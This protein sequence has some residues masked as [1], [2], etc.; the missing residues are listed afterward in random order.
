MTAEDVTQGMLVNFD[1]VERVIADRNQFKIRLAIGEDAYKLLGTTKKLRELWDIL[2]TAGTGAAIAK[3]SFVASTFFA[4]TGLLGMLGMGTAVTPI[5]WVAFAALA[6]GGA[7]YGLYRL[8]G[9]VTSDRVHVIPV[10]LNTPLDVLGMA[11]FD[12]IVPLALRIAAVDGEIGRKEKVHLIDHLV[13]EWGFDE[14]YVRA[15]LRQIEPDVITRSIGTLTMELATFLHLNPD[16]NH[17]EMAQKIGD[18]LQ[19]MLEAEGP[20]CAQESDAIALV[21]AGLKSKP[22]SKLYEGWA[23]A[24]ESAKG[25]A[26]K[27][28]DLVKTKAVSEGKRG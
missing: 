20:L 7:C 10:F 12:L 28:V 24:R 6:S 2:G 19:E 27:A 22:P 18:F 8:F 16:C 26:D 9:N 15:G 3:S 5:G 25:L 13:Q 17:K 4:P 1:G 11:L 14:R 21:R 23:K